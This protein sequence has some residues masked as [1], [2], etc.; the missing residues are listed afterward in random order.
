MTEPQ[1]DPR[2]DIMFEPVRIGPVVARNRFFQV[3]Q[4]SGMGYRDVSSHA[5]MRATKAEGGWAVVCTEQAEIHHTSEITPFIEQRLWDD[6]DL[7][8][9]ELTTS[10][11]HDHGALAAIELC[12]NGMNG[13]NFFS[14]VPPMG[15]GHLPVAAFSYDPVQARAMTLADIADLRRWHRRAVRRSIDAGFDLVYVYAGH[16]LGGIHHFLSRRYNQRTD[17]KS[18]RLNS[19]HEWISRMPSSA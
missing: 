11:V 18:T 6:I 15:P 3:P 12:Y 2:F 7:P 14:R 16:A 4:C 17:R 10:R 5:E 9:L 1:R 19:S 8:A 13:P